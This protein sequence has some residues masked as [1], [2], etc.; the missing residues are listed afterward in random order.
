MYMAN[1]QNAAWLKYFMIKTGIFGPTLKTIFVKKGHF[2]FAHRNSITKCGYV[3]V[4]LLL[5]GA[6]ESQ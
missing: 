3:W 5:S 2:K 4:F 6:E 1:G